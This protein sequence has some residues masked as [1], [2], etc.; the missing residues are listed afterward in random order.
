VL[1]NIAKCCHPLPGDE[2]K[3]YIS[4]GKG[5]VVHR[6]DCPNLKE[7]SKTNEDRIIDV[8]WSE[9][10]NIKLPFKITTTTIDKPGMLSDITTNLKRYG[11]NIIELSARPLKDGKALQSFTIELSGKSQLDRIL[12][13]L[14]SLE[15]LIDIKY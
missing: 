7:I 1:T 8:S 12:S 6:A 10:K 14:Q 11:N 13:K 15:G 2:L 9:G 3:G 5:L 4:V